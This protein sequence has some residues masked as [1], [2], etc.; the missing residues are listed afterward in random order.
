MQIGEPV[1]TIVVEP[2]ELPVGEPK[3]QPG[4]LAEPKPEP[5]PEP[6]TP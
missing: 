5:E 6:A 3:S 1:K 2:L 4:P